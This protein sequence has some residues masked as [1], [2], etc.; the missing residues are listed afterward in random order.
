VVDAAELRG[1]H[2]ATHREQRKRVGQS[3]SPLN[4]QPGKSESAA[5]DVHSSFAISNPKI[6]EL[7]KRDLIID[8]FSPGSSCQLEGEPLTESA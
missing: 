5:V 2:H 3:V 6:S 1:T 8:Q 4:N 7:V